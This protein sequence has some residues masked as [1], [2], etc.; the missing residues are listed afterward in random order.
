MQ[1]YRRREAGEQSGKL[2]LHPHGRGE[3]MASKPHNYMRSSVI[4]R[5]HGKRAKGLTV[6]KIENCRILP[7]LCCS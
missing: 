4:M 6:D 2:G 7:L 5:K 1:L 3:E